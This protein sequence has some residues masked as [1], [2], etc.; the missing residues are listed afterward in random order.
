M[1]HGVEAKLPFPARSKTVSAATLTDTFAPVAV[2]AR[3]YSLGLSSVNLPAIALFKK[4]SE[5][6]NP[7]ISSENLIAKRIDWFVVGPG[8]WFDVMLA[9]GF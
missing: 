2:M 6:S 9:V 7:E 4:T 1:D 8:S 5:A 3:V